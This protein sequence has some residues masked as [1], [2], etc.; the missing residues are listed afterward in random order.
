MLYTMLSFYRKTDI[1]LFFSPLSNLNA[2]SR[3]GHHHSVH[4]VVVANAELASEHR[5]VVMTTNKLARETRCQ[6]Q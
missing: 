2:L 6:R 4:A 3:V 5:V 1:K